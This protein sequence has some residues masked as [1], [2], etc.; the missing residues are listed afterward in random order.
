VPAEIF[1]ILINKIL[2]GKNHTETIT[3]IDAY[4]TSVDAIISRIDMLNKTEIKNELESITKPKE[5]E[6]FITAV[7]NSIIAILPLYKLFK[8]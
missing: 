2:E 1:T 8:A 3:A 5:L 4:L 7:E 6:S